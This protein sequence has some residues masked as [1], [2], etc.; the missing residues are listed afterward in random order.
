MSWSYATPPGRAAARAS[1]A[2]TTVGAARRSTTT[3]SLPRPFIF[4][5]G[6][7]ASPLIIASHE[8]PLYGRR[9][10]ITSQASQNGDQPCAF[11]AGRRGPHVLTL[12]RLAGGRGLQ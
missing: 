2:V 10:R 6:W 12:R 11:P 3:I 9:V 5:K 7:S 4:T 8:R 1:A